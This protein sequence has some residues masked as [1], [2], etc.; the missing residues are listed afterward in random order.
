MSQIRRHHQR[1]A[2]M[3]P[4][5]PDPP[6]WHAPEEW[7]TQAELAAELQ[8]SA[9]Q[10]QN[11]EPR[12]LP[13]RGERGSK[14]YPKWDCLAW[15]FA[16]RRLHDQDRLS[17]PDTLD[18]DEARR[19]YESWIGLCGAYFT[20]DASRPLSW[21]AL[22]HVALARQLRESG[23]HPDDLLPSGFRSIYGLG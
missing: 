13:S 21:L 20:Q 3:P 10:V 23:G 6:L 22:E 1:P 2:W 9:R 15:Y 7:I 18:I 19:V 16:W 11:L 17:L 5:I 12:G 8:I 14:R 4:E